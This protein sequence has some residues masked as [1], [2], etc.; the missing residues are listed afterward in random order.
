MI[1]AL[2]G[3]MHHVITGVSLICLAQKREKLFSV[4]TEVSFKTLTADQIT[5]YISQVHTLDKAGAYAI[6]EHGD[7]IIDH[8]DG[9]HSNVVGLPMEM[10]TRELE[11]WLT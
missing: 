9:S 7:F 3:K 8:I 4:C 5:M 2:S 10:L 6:Q 11:L 1:E